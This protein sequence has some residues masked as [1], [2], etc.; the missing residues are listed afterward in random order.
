MGTLGRYP[1]NNGASIS[2]YEAAF[3]GDFRRQ[4]K[5]KHVV[6]PR[7][8]GHFTLKKMYFPVLVK[9]RTGVQY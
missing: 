4:E 5:A 8:S 9:T 1:T 7:G 2:C 6:L 3:V